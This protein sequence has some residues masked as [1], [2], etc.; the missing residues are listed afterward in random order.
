VG[1]KIF[2]HF[3]LYPSISVGNVS[4]FVRHFFHHQYHGLSQFCNLTQIEMFRVLLLR[5]YLDIT[6]YWKLKTENW[7][8]CN[9]I[10]FKYVNSTVELN[11]NENFVE[12]STCRS[13][14]QCTGPTKLDA[15]AAKTKLSKLMLQGLQK[16]IMTI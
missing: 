13:S 1:G 4:P 8:Y 15:D 16:F 7:K 10:I 11:F 14:K 12:Q 9:K 5:V 6:Y 2:V 3:Q